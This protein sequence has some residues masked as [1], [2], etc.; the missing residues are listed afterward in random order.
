MNSTPPIA[1]FKISFVFG[2]VWP[3]YCPTSSSRVTDTT[4][5]LRTK[6]SPCRMLAIRSATVVLPVPGFPV[7][8]MCSVGTSEVS[9]IRLRMRSISSSEAISRMR[10]LTGF[11]PISSRSSCVRISSMP[12]DSSSSRRLTLPVIA[13]T[14][15]S[16]CETST[17]TTGALEKNSVAAFAATEQ[18]I[19]QTENAEGAV[20]CRTGERYL[21][22]APPLRTIAGIGFGGV[23]DVAAGHFVPLEAE[24]GLLLRPVDD[25]RQPQRFPT[26]A[27]IERR[28]PDIPVAIDLAAFIQF[29]QHAGGVAQIEHR[30][31]PHFPEAVAGVRIVGEFDVHRPAI[32]QAI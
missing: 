27:G 15:R 22:V 10:V 29:H 3:I 7:N 28:Q 32:G 12:T 24:A 17:R 19:Q 2:A 4:C 6:P 1:F 21:S 11:S 14:F 8:D 30:Q 13:A 16:I 26:M 9:P 5:P 20:C 31:A 23:A 18:C 25:E